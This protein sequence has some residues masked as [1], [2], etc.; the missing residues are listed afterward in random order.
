MLVIQWACALAL[1]ALWLQAAQHKLRDRLR[2][3]ANLDA[4]RLSPATMTPLLTRVI[5]LVELSLAVTLLVPSV[6]IYTAPTSAAVLTLYGAAIG[7]NLLRGRTHIDCGCGDVPQ[8]V[9]SALLWRNGMLV[10][11]SLIL[12]VPTAA[13]LTLTAFFT[14][15][16]G[17]ALFIL[18][19]WSLTLT[20]ENASRLREWSA[21]HG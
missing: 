16:L 7:I 15:T 10:L 13:S 11:A 5:P 14:A 12:L 21:S 19:Y 18:T 3:G 2:F 20:L 17:A 8:L 1:A 4:Y 9:S 6:W